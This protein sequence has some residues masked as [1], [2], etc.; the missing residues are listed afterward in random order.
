MPNS[1]PTQV[2]LRNGCID[3]WWFR[4]TLNYFVWLKSKY[5][6]LNIRDLTFWLRLCQPKATTHRTSITNP[7]KSY[8]Q[9]LLHRYTT[10]AYPPS[11]NVTKWFLWYESWPQ[12]PNYAESKVKPIVSPSVLKYQAVI[13]VVASTLFYLQITQLICMTVKLPRYLEFQRADCI[14]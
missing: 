9:Q 10:V 1:S 6:F 2:V 3:T 8:S 11:A 13:K 5:D 12:D 7:D 14:S 4:N